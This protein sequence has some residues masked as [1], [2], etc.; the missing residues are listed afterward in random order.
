MLYENYKKPVYQLAFRLLKDADRAADATQEAFARAFKSWPKF[1]NESK[2]ETWV[3]RIAYNLCLN[4]LNAKRFFS[5]D[6]D[7]VEKED[8]PHTRPDAASQSNETS[9]LVRRAL[10]RLSEDDRR[11]LCLQMGENLD[12]ED[13][14]SV[15]GCPVEA[16]RMRVCRARKR[17][18]EILEPVMNQEVGA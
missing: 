16:L 15:L 5:S 6:Q 13:L 3:Y 4:A 1:R 14:A 17:L 8:Y 12:Y 11:L 10:A 9:F 7:G 2:P 18:R